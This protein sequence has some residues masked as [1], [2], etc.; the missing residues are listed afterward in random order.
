MALPLERFAS[1]QPASDHVTK[2]SKQRE[3]T[4]SWCHAVLESMASEEYTLTLQKTVVE[5][6][7]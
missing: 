1:D 7:L 4:A 2:G 5:T 6:S 3:P